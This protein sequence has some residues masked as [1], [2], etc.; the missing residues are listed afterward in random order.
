MTNEQTELFINLL[1]SNLK[2]LIDKADEELG[3][4]KPVRHVEWEYIG[5]SPLENLKFFGISVESEEEAK[6]KSEDWIK[7]KGG[8][9]ALDGLRELVD[10]L[11]N[12]FEE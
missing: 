11:D 7:V 6:E 12:P 2:T 4:K 9:V 3:N 1:K 5:S 8:V 10:G